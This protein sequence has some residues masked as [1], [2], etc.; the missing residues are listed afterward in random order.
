MFLKRLIIQNE[1]ETIRDIVFYKGVNFIV[2]ETPSSQSQ[3][4]TGNN[5]GKTTVLRL[6]HYC[7]GGDGQNIYKD[8]EFKKQPNT[9]I[10]NFLK[11]NN[12]IITVILVEDI[13]DDNNSHQIIVKKNFLTY[14]KKIQEI[15]GENIPN[16]NDF[17]EQLKKLVF[18]SEIEKP[19]FKQIISKNIR[20]EKNRMTNIVKVLNPYTRPEEYEALYLFWLGL[21]FGDM[22]EKYRL[23]E[24]KK[25][26]ERLQKHLEK[27][28]NLPLIEQALSFTLGK[29]EEFNQKKNT[30]NIN[31]D[32]ASDI[33]KLNETKYQL[34]ITASELGKLE[35]RKELIN[36]SKD[37]L[38]KEFAQI[39][40]AQIK[41]LYKQAQAFIPN[42]QVSFE[43]TVKFHNDLISEKLKYITKD[44]PDLQKSI[45]K[46]KSRLL[47]LRSEESMF[48][49]KLQKTGIT[50]ELEKIVVILNT[51]YERK[52]KLE[53]QK[54]MW[55]ES[56]N[57]LNI[58][59]SK[60]QN[61][62]NKITSN[63]ELIKSR[64]TEFNKYFPVI[65]NK[66][67]GEDY[68]LSPKKNKQCYELNIDNIDGNPSTGKKKGQISAFDFAYIL[69]ADALDIKCLHFIMHD[70]LENIHD[71]QLTTLFEVANNINCQ[72]IVSIL[73]DKIPVNVDVSMFEVLSL[74]QDNKLFR[75]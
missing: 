54:R 66:L 52:G 7:L 73:R 63:D 22:S 10:E 47:K 68:F 6:V 46:V 33:D 35:L 41:S 44:L 67:Y 70:Q 53:E 29:I 71:N 40:S 60:L 14:K 11:E 65:S 15:N 59:D 31:V 23:S 37:D 69:F 18:N 58:I 51:Q 34:N 39:D 30:F 25:A 36:E 16:D 1:Q 2:D 56:L 13:E 43:D 45:N 38:E 42:I 20:D 32:Y 4:T 49:E 61:I 74:S 21:E 5:V 24:D 48:T 72:Y 27:E 75:V 62:N 3:Q 28:S 19:T 57:K 8:T 50:E 64:V 9:I 12:I 26:E 17:D 55:E